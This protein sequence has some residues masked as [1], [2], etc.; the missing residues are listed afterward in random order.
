MIRGKAKQ[1]GYKLNEFG[2]YDAK[3]GK[4]VEGLKSEKDIMEKLE[5]NFIPMSRRRWTN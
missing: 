5:L 4:V 3:T 1:L 2:L